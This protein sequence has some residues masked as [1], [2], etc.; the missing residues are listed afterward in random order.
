MNELIEA[1]YNIGSFATEDLSAW[2]AAIEKDAK[3]GP[4]EIKPKTRE[5][6]LELLKTIEEEYP[7]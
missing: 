3:V 1:L 5:A 6:I 2:N 7:K 4:F